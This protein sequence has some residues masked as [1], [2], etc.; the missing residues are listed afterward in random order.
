VRLFASLNPDAVLLDDGLLAAAEYLSQHPEAG[1]A[2]GQILNVDGSVQAE[3]RAF[4]RPPQRVLQPPL[5]DHEALPE[6]PLLRDY[7][8]S[9]WAHDA[10]RP[11]DW[12]SARSCSSTGAPSMP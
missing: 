4:P 9:G 3:L 2:G 6:Q 7:L 8:M 10:I 12:V 5:A 11:V 1:V